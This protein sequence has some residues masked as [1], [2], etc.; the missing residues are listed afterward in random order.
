MKQPHIINESALTRVF[1][2][3][4]CVLDHAAHAGLQADRRGDDDPDQRSGGPQ[5]GLQSG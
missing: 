3:H 4:L 1:Y 2:L 5:P